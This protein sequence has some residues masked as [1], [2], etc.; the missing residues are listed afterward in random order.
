MKKTSL[1]VNFLA[2]D[3]ERK[4]RQSTVL[5]AGVF[6]VLVGLLAAVGA[7]ASYRAATRGVDVFTEVGSM[8][9]L[10]ELRK[11]VWNDAT[12]SG[13]DLFATPDGKL[14]VLILGIG[15]EGHDGAQLTDTILLASYDR[16]RKKLGLVS[17]PRD[18]AYPLG[19]G[20]FEKINSVNAYAEL[21]APGQGAKQTAVQ[22]AKLFDTR[23]DRV[24]RI[25]FKGFEQF[26]DA[27]GGID[28][29]V[30][31]T[32]TDNQF[33]TD[34]S[35]PDPYKW[36]SVT[37]TKGVEHMDGARA[38]TYARSRHSF[39]GEGSDFARSRRQQLVVKAVRERFLSVGTLAN[40]KKVSDIWTAISSHVQTDFS[41]WDLLK[42]AP[43][44]RSYSDVAITS[45]VLTDDPADGE[46]V[47][48]MVDGAFMLFPKKSDWSD[49]RAIVANPFESKK[50]VAEDQR[51]K[52]VTLEVKNGTLRAGYA[53][54]VATTLERGG[55]DVLATGN[56]RLRNYERTVIY[57]LTDGAKVDELVKLKKI[58]NANVA[59]VPA[60]KE[61]L[62]P[63]GSRENVNATSAQFLV[64]LGGS[65]VSLIDPY[66]GTPT[67]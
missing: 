50:Q 56:A 8:L 65:S 61:I 24:V 14:N 30:E 32:F 26:I 27:L 57:D 51:A 12:P 6:S 63:D 53:S 49:I 7:G 5:V 52:G 58:L 35:G 19:G 20:R 16:E 42:L 40:P 4:A 36:T 28:V 41:A 44:A 33:P 47:A 48:G 22:F 60:S 34:D 1:K 15:G 43:E 29:T 23:I 18:L 46:L 13:T 38:L 11:I 66:A 9:S 62:L 10:T 64:I 25:D 17:I 55:Y 59:S 45:Q 31:K 2:T 39:G 37:F 54:Q 21:D 67:P 3:A